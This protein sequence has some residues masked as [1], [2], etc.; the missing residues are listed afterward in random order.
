MTRLAAR[1]GRWA[2]RPVVAGQVARRPTSCTSIN[3]DTL[4]LVHARV[5]PTSSSK[6]VTDYIDADV[7]DPGK[8]L[9]DAARTRD[10]TQPVALIM[11]G[12]AGN[13]GQR[14][15]H[16]RGAFD[17]GPGSRLPYR[18]AATW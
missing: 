9:Q 5:L 6:G 14:R 8:I 12:I 7:G 11:L 13:H 1:S 16:R 10:L 2:S 4:V 17:R 15:R 18:P 3:N